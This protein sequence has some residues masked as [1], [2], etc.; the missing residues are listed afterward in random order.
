MKTLDPYQLPL[1]SINL[2]E[3]S[4][5]TG[6]SWTV[7]LLYLRLILEKALTVD[8]ILVVT[9]TEAATM[10]LR[11]DVRNRL[12]EALD[13]LENPHRDNIKEEYKRIAERIAALPLERD[14]AIRRLKLAKLSIDEAAIFTIHGFCRRTLSENAFEA[15]L[16]FECELMDDDF[17][18]KQQLVD[19]FW[20]RHFEQAPKALLFKLQQENITPDSLLNSIRI[21]SGT[22]YLQLCGPHYAPDEKHWDKLEKAFRIALETWCEARHELECLLCN[23]DREGEYQKPFIKVRERI[24]LEMDFLSGLAGMPATID[25]KLLV[26]LGAKEKTTAKF[27]SLEHPFFQQWQEFLDLWSMLNQGADN[28]INQIRIDLIKHLE[29]ELPREKQRRGVLSFDDLLLQ[30]QQA[31]QNNENLATGLRNK[32]PAALIDEFQEL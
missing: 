9:F 26:W 7:T 10:E 12:V 4:A 31:L 6:K 2:I 17:E 16:P 20:R 14:E 18:L 5:G 27:A 1:Q 23:P 22:P 24:L 11:D 3:A 13:A 19:D 25:S 21:A 15:A 32:Y 30:L 29:K 8:Q 28:Y